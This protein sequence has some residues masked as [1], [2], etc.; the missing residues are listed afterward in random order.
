VSRDRR[1]SK[2]LDA[3][4]ILASP[5]VD[6]RLVIAVSGVS[7]AFSFSLASL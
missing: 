3:G 4:S 1:G 7:V 5:V 6:E 2:L